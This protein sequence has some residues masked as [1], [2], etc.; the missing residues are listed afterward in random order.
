MK[1]IELH[2]IIYDYE[3]FKAFAEAFKLGQEDLILTNEYIYKPFIAALNLPCPVIYQEKYGLG[4][5]TDVMVDAILADMK[6]IQYKRLIAVGGG[7][8]ID[9][10]KVLVLDQA[11]SV[12]DL[13][14][15]SANLKKRCELIIVPTTC[16]TGSEVTGISVINRTRISAKMGLASPAMFADYAVLIPEFLN[17]LPYPV[18]ATSS[19]DALIHAVESYLSPNCTPFTELF[20]VAAIRLIIQGY[21]KIREKGKDARFEDSAEYLRASTFAGIAFGNAG[22]AAV[23]AMSYVFGSKYH[24]AHGESNYQFFTEVLRTYRQKAPDQ[25]IKA[26]ETMLQHE[27]K[28]TGDAFTALDD[29][30]TEIL[31]LKRMNQYGATQDDIFTFAQITIDRQQRLLKN[32]YVYLDQ[33]DLSNIFHSRL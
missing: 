29:L 13:Y 3:S 23:H 28:I 4:E 1:Q 19:I 31:P 18:F 15:N 17:S 6:S 32:N 27:I 14:D 33:I 7:T 30:L 9:I 16:G 2:P 11:D 8:I 25:K 21:M 12:D 10:S 20:S 24:V 5:P 26:L 22:C